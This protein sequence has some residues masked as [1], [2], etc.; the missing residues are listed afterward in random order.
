MRRR[1]EP[2]SSHIVN[3]GLASGPPP[4]DHQWAVFRPG[5]RLSSAAPIGV[6]GQFT[7]RLG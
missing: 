4:M 6:I 5:L 1:G 2:I 7:G 3:I